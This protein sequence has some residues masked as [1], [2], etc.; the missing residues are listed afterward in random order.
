ME[1]KM[2]KTE[3]ITKNYDGTKG[4]EIPKTMVQPKGGK[5]PTKM[6]DQKRRKYL[7]MKGPKTKTRNE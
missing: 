1:E 5:N 6:E 2:K 4:P 3:Q 7:R